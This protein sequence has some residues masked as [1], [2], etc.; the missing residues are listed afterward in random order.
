MAHQAIPL[1]W[2][3]RIEA[4]A[5]PL[6]ALL[7]S[8]LLFGLFLA[9]LGKNPAEVFLIIYKG[10]FGSTFSW[11]NSLARAAPLIL[12]GFCVAWPAQAGLM[13]IGGEGAL[14]LGGLGAA[15]AGGLMTESNALLAQ[16]VMLAAGFVTGALW[17]MMVG[18]L[19]Q[20]RG[21][22]E[23]I[24]S[25]L[26]T[27]IALALFNQLVEGPL[28]D[29]AS[30]N[31][32]STM[33][34]GDSHMLHGLTS[35]DLHAGL[36]Y[37]ICF[38]F[39][40]FIVVRYTTAGFAL[41]VV[42]GNPRAALLAGLPTSML[43]LFACGMG[44]GAAGLAGAIEVAAV[45][46]SANASINAGYGYTGILVALLARQNAL[47]I[48][49]VSILLGGIAASGGLLQ[50]RLDLPDATVL[51]LQGLVFLVV[52]ASEALYGRIAKQLRWPAR[53]PKVLIEGIAT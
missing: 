32:P 34:I 44:G 46:G 20:W 3:G 24:S 12:C 14:V 8:M 47:A 35:F 13:I 51:V 7:V 31:K 43:V 42:G 40:S 48:I 19:R 26:L 29:P 18:A 30:L 53:A 9:L 27:Y 45:H 37:G 41:R 33:P 6:F 23:T 17:I 50:R 1:R 11:R 52:L 25:L 4:V 5:I 28:R 15:V 49:P 10:G 2:Q 22:N 39:L 16:F 36:P 38:A 21:V